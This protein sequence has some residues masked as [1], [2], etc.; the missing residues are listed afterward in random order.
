MLN[1]VLELVLGGMRGG[2]PENFAKKKAAG[3]C[4]TALMKLF[5][6]AI[7]EYAELTQ[8]FQI[9]LVLVELEPGLQESWQ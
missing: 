6:L 5:L 7:L 8:L 4:P 2:Q 3:L 9:V 1:V